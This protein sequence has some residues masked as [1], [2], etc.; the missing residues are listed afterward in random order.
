MGGMASTSSSSSTSASSTSAGSTSA[1]STSASS[2][3]AGVG[4]MGTGG[5]A[6]TS[7]SSSGSPTTGFELQYLCDVTAAMSV[8]IQPYFQVINHGPA[9]VPLSSLTIRYFY[10]KDGNTSADQNFA[11]DYAQV[12]G[13]GIT[14]SVS[15]VFNTFTGTDADEYVEIHFAS[16]SGNLEPGVASPVPAIVQARIWADGFPTLDQTTDYSFNP[17]LT[18]YTDWTHITLYQNGNLVWGVEP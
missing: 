15:A 8:Q 10:Q 7:A 6:S 9:A 3:S 2:T 4:G 13:T 1:S 17:N 12:G 18:Q 14:G 11:C 5:M 16:G